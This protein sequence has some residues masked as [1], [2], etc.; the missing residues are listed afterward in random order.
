MH[1]GDHAL[2][3]VDPLADRMVSRPSLQ[4]EHG[5]LRGGTFGRGHVPSRGA[6]AQQVPMLSP[7]TPELK[8]HETRVLEAHRQFPLP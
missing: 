3:L 6:F 4:L 1:T 8:M 2:E 7:S 5:L